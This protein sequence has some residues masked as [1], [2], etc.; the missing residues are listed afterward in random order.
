VL[1]ASVT[2]LPLWASIVL[3]LASPAVAA[4]AILIGK[5]TQDATLRQQQEQLT[6]QL[7]QQRDQFEQQLAL[8]REELENQRNIQTDQ[9]TDQDY[10]HHETL[11]H[12]RQ[13]D[14]LREVRSVLD[15]A[16]RALNEADRIHR[17]IGAGWVRT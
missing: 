1:L 15:D 17:D 7:A 10:Q 5:H 2:V 9:L 14:D 6:Q 12:E 3:A 4:V 13:R 16:V 8:Q 11:R